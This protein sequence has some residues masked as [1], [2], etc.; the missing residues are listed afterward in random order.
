MRAAQDS[1]LTAQSLLQRLQAVIP[2]LS[3]LAHLA[4]QGLIQP[5]SLGCTAPTD[6]SGTH[7]PPPSGDSLA[8]HFRVALKQS[9]QN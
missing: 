7:F 6:P 9:I 8:T 1:V 4:L 5:Y 2:L 3:S